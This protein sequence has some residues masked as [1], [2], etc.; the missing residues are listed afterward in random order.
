MPLLLCIQDT[1]F[2]PFL[3]QPFVLVLFFGIL[4]SPGVRNSLYLTPT[5][6]LKHGFK[7]PV[8]RGGAYMHSECSP[9]GRWLW[10]SCQYSYWY[11]CRYL[12]GYCPVVPCLSYDPPPMPGSV[13]WGI[14]HSEAAWQEGGI[15]NSRTNGTL[16]SGLHYGIKFGR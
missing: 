11:S 16:F 5:L 9:Q 13:P 6:V 12:H 14:T 4:C 10:C 2:V 3:P 7:L 1:V 8:F 15:P